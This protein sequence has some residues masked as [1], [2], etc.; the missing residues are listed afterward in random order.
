MKFALRTATIAAAMIATRCVCLGQVAGGSISGAV[1]DSTGA[2]V[3]KAQVSV[4]NS[5]TQVARSVDVNDDG[6]YSAPNLVPGTYEITASATGFETLVHSG[7]V[8]AV[9]AEQVVDFQLTPGSVQTKIEVT[10]TPPAIELATSSLDA[11]TNST[12]V[13]E[14]PLNGRDW[15]LLAALQPGVTGVNQSPL[16]ISN[17]RANRGLGTQL[18]VGGTRPQANN[19][20]LDGISI[21]DYSNAGPGSILGVVLGVEAVQEFSVV[22]NS[23]PASYGRT[24]GG[25]INS[26]TRSGTNELHGSAYEFIRN[27]ALDARNFF[28]KTSSPPAFR[29]NQFGADAGGP[30]IKDKTFIFGDY[31]GVRQSLTTTQSNVVPSAAARTGQLSTGRVSVD[32][33]V[34]PYLALYPLPNTPT[35]GDTGIFALAT[36]QSTREDFFTTRVDHT[37]SKN[38]TLFG[39]YMFDDGKTRSR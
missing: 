31:E 33:R 23:A 30:I 27:S 1:K 8:V 4:K 20:R 29:R 37:L 26:I 36:P 19:Y 28:D 15:T 18:S 3:G 12:T 13:R 10:G 39:T 24:A 22:T 14:L 9:G 11:V 16:G 35:S 5:E 6:I 34:V 25:V 21:N 38:D 32:P 17:Q 2:A 7:V